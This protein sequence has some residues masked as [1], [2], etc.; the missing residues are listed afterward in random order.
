MKQKK[1]YIVG[2]GATARVGKDLFAD[3]FVKFAQNL[4]Y[5][6]G[7]YA[8]ASE[9]KNDLAPFLKDKCGMNVWTEETSEKAKFRDLLVA[10]GK[11]Q[12]M[13]SQGTYWTSLLLEKIKQDAINSMNDMDDA[14]DSYI[15][16]VSDIRYDFFPKDEAHWVQN[17]NGFLIYLDRDGISPANIDEQENAPKIKEKADLCVSW[18]NRGEPN[19]EDMDSYHANVVK[20]AF[21]K[22]IMEKGL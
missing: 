6:A 3:Y 16:V 10:Y 13:E 7:K 4:G 12:R 21:C 14:R 22:F 18:G 1:I 11:I 8:L 20:M 5:S 2:I 15:A 17:N 9:L 19:R